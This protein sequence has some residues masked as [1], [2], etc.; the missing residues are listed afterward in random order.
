MKH[1]YNGANQEEII[2][3]YEKN[4]DKIII[5]FL[6][7]GMYEVP[8]TKQNEIN[9]LDKMFYQATERNNNLSIDELKKI[10]KIFIN[11]AVI[12]SVLCGQSVLIGSAVDP[13]SIISKFAAFIFGC[14]RGSAMAYSIEY[15]LLA[16]RIMELEK[17]DIYLKIKSKLEKIDNPTLFN[18]I[19]KSK[20]ITPLNINTLDN[21][22]L[23][24]IKNIRDNLKK[25]EKYQSYFDSE[26]NNKTFAKRINNNENKS[27]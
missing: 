15:I 10:K 27:L 3:N 21:Y 5:N 16:N 1:G 20:N 9:L 2:K 24:D 25:Y 19:K 18:G 22:S 17:Y 13:E 7:G 6:D 11:G 14:A 12:N 23:S 8:L 4:D 26:D